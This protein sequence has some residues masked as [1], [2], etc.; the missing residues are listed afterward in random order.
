MG[1]INRDDM[2]EL[3][4]R[5][6]LKR[7]CFGRV[8]GGYYDHNGSLEGT[9]NTLFGKLSPAEQSR[10]LAVAKAIPFAETNT[11]L[12]E[13]RFSEDEKKSYAW[14]TLME[15]NRCE[16]KN[17][18]MLENLYEVLEGRL[19]INQACCVYVFQGLYD[20]PLKGTDKQSQW[21]SEEV[22]KFLICAVC[23][24]NADYV[25]GEPEE[26]FL[27]PAFVDRSSNENR[28]DLYQKDD[29]DSSDGL[30]YLFWD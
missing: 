16:L 22:Y 3:T 26:G 27:F 12:K 28:I 4:R 18:A 2:L 8:A 13:Y 6:T 23:P 11:K 7:H 20:I 14:R 15:L 9:F 24:I 21:E 29:S 30:L 5:M 25:P 1:K 17:D 10:L 19:D